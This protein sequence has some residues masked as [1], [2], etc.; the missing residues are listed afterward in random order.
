LPNPFTAKQLQSPYPILNS[1]GRH[2]PIQISNPV[3]LS[4]KSAFR[5]RST[6]PDTFFHLKRLI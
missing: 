4:H 3:S 5:P 6:F 2:W 1:I